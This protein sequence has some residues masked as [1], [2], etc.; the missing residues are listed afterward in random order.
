[1]DSI[2]SDLQIT[3][4]KLQP[5]IT[6]TRE[7]TKIQLHKVFQRFVITYVFTKE[8]LQVV[9]ARLQT[10]RSSC[11]LFMKNNSLSNVEP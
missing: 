5:V 9:S 2:S 11:S 8:K 10:A 1:M 6:T 4:Y 7:I 3:I